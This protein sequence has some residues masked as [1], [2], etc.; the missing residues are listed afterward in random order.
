MKL[1]PC[2][3]G[4][5]YQT[6]CQPYHNGQPP[7]TPEALMRSRYAAYAL[8]K[9]GYVLKTERPDSPRLKTDVAAFRKDLKWFCEHTEFVGLHILKQATTSLEQATVTFHAVLIQDGRDAS[10]TERSLFEKVNGRWLYVK[11]VTGRAWGA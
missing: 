4:E 8:G 9:V 5:P 11:P 7:P 10:F 3:S 6:C 1:C 2:H